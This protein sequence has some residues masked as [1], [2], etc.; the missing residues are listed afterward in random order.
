VIYLALDRLRQRWR[1]RAAARPDAPL[2]L[3]SP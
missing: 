2:A 3:E 1:S